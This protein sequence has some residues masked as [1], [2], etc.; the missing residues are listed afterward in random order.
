[1]SIQTELLLPVNKQE[2]SY[3]KEKNVSKTCVKK[4]LYTCTG[5]RRKK[6]CERSTEK[7]S[8]I[9]CLSLEYKNEQWKHI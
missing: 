6:N 1:M 4:M 5:I 3:T 8:F 2:S 9:S 7:S